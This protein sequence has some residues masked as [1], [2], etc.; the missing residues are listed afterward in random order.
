[1]QRSFSLYCTSQRQNRQP[2]PFEVL[3]N[4]ADGMDW[5]TFCD[6]SAMYLVPLRR[7]LVDAA[8]SVSNGAGSSAPNCETYFAWRIRTDVRL[9]SVT[10]FILPLGLGHSAERRYGDELGEKPICG[11]KEKGTSWRGLRLVNRGPSRA[12]SS[13]QRCH[14]SGP[15]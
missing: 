1:M 7:S 11:P 9:T 8:A 2:I 3:L 4:G 10:K 12:G 5:E 13:L 15:G 6:C 14:V